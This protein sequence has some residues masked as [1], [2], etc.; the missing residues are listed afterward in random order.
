MAFALR[1]SR[2]GAPHHRRT[3]EIGACLTDPFANGEGWSNIDTFTIPEG[4]RRRVYRPKL[5]FA[6]ASRSMSIQG[7]AAV[8]RTSAR[9]MAAGGH[10][11]ALP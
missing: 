5:H 10:E 8:R 11:F 9:V 6:P 1:K 3:E 2:M 7:H 4:R